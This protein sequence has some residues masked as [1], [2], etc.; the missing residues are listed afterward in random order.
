MIGYS[1]YGKGR[2][3]SKKTN[4]YGSK[5]SYS[6]Y[7][8]G[9]SWDYWGSYFN[10]PL[11][12][13]DNLVVRDPENYTTPSK[14]DIE[15]KANI[16]RQSAVDQIKELARV[17]YFKMI[18]DKN[19]FIDEYADF[20]NLADDVKEQLSAKKALYDSIYETFIPGFTPLDQA[21]A[22]Y[23]QMSKE[24]EKQNRE[25]SDDVDQEMLNGTQLNFDREMYMDPS[26][27]EQLE[28]NE[29]SKN[30][31][32]S[33]MN[34]ISIIGELGT[35]FKVE[36]EIDEKIVSNSDIY[37]KKMMR[38]YAQIANIDLYQ[39]LFP[40]FDVKLLTK[41]FVVN[42]PV[43]R[44]EQKQKI[45]ILLD[46][47]GS[48][49]EQ[50]KQDWVN[51]ILIDRFKY[52][53]RGEAEVFFSYFVCSPDQMNF[54]H[55]HDRETVIKFWQTFSNDPD[56]GTTRV[57][58]MVEKVAADIKKKKLHNLDIDLSEEKPE[59]LIIN[60]G[61][62]FIDS[63]KFPYKVNAICLME[64]NNQLKNLCIATHGKQVHV[65]YDNNV[66]A[67]SESGEEII[68]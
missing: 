9:G 22:I 35:Q 57:G 19:Y 41:D 1:S 59:I 2:S 58:T 56:G 29:H 66:V 3:S 5:K 28:L 6:S 67:Y 11:E 48:M 16:W 26:I 10:D 17:C 62:D 50:E 15:A 27:N 30:R 46:F 45:I 39:K 7:S 52:V 37:A 21:I 68:N 12:N 51:A 64:Q 8:Y 40:N 23:K 4:Y 25:D 20:E 54:Q 24:A 53:M 44:K 61:E 55:I 63:S 32:M 14:R 18:G 43:D 38:D 60:D 34:N 47:S 36:K 31:K 33:I 65:D 49:D 13:D 42:V